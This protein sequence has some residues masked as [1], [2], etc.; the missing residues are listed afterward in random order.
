M[1]LI[2]GSEFQMHLE[3][4]FGISEINQVFFCLFAYNVLALECALEYLRLRR[5]FVGKVG[6]QYLLAMHKCTDQG[7]SIAEAAV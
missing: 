6:F 4:V 2:I 3:I 1:G 7:I 5:T